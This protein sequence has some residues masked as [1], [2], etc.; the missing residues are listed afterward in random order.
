[1]DF[2]VEPEETNQSVHSGTVQNY[3]SFSNLFL[4]DSDDYRKKKKNSLKESSF[5][6][7]TPSPETLPLH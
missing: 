3:P 5:P 7:S 6:A 4:P 1:M 2:T